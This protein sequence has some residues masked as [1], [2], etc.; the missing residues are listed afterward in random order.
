MQVRHNC[1][2][3]THQEFLVHATLSAQAHAPECTQPAF[4]S[5]SIL[6]R[7]SSTMMLK[8]VVLSTVMLKTVVLSTVMLKT[9]MLSTYLLA[10]C[11]CKKAPG[12]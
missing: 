10:G 4:N 7:F 9:V 11:N 2:Q 12:N 1:I 6:G 5:F 8:T 3:C